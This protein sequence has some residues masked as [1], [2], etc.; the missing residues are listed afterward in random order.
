MLYEVITES[1]LYT[2][3]EIQ[4]EAQ[5]P[6]RFQKQREDKLTLRMRKIGKRLGL[7]TGWAVL[8]FT[9]IFRKESYNF[10]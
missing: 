3:Q 7:R 10:V 4:V 8:S 6:E 2:F 9:N 5:A 1:F